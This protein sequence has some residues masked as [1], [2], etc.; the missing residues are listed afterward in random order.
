[1]LRAA[2]AIDLEVVEHFEKVLEKVQGEILM[3]T[4]GIIFD[5]NGIRLKNEGGTAA[6]AP[7][8][9]IA[10]TFAV[11]ARARAIV[12]IDMHISRKG[13]VLLISVLR[14]VIIC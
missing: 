13:I 9:A 3:C 5:W 4:N 8:A 14:Y 7:C 10:Y 12:D 2:I 1:M 11:Q 6:P